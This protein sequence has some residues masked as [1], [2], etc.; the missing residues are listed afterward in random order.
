MAANQNST[1]ATN[2]TINS[3][4]SFLN[5]GIGVLTF[6]ITPLIMLA[7][8]LLSPDWTFGEI[9]GLRPILHQLWILVS[10]VVYVI[11]GFM[12]V[13]I[14]FANIFGGESS[15]AYEMK[16]MLPK[17]VTGMLIVPFTWF[18]VS[19]VLSISNI[20]TASVISLPMETIL[21][22]GGETSKLLADPIIPKQI[23]FNKNTDTGTESTTTEVKNGNF[24]ASN[25]KTDSKNC[26]SIKEFLTNGGGGA[27]NLLSV[28]AYGIFRI[29]DYKALTPE[30]KVN[31]VLDIAYKL[32]F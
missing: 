14:A 24:T 9:F 10:N 3:I 18:I 29:Q 31:K 7:G 22:A 20:L 5:L 12:L 13:F 19:A 23:T 4:I 8:W 28:Y 27:Y 26:L 25:C 11:F 6:L 17:L 2:A 32:G 30:E 16:T 21:K 15:K 1:D